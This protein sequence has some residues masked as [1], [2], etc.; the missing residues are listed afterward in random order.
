MI[1]AIFLTLAAVVFLCWLLFTLAAYAL[2][3]FAGMLAGQWAH[4][5]GAGL[6]GALAVALLAGVVTFIAGQ[7]LLV[8]V[9][10]P[11]VRAAVAI[12]FVV[13]A[14]VAGFSAAHG[15]ARLGVPSEA[16]RDAFGV[17]GAFAVGASAWVRLTST[18]V[19]APEDRPR[20]VEIFPGSGW[21]GAG[22]GRAGE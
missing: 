5:A 12:L 7:L 9:R 11:L 2:P 6:L 22:P 3:L 17:I 18:V 8:T 16:W 21:R 1:I 10:S 20:P 14:A 19:L 15:L 4:A 13:P